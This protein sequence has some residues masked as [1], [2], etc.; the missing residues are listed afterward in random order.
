MEQK[1]SILKRPEVVKMPESMGIPAIDKPSTGTSKEVPEV[2]T[3]NPLITES[4]VEY[5]NYRI[6]QEEYSSRIYM[7]M[8]MWLDEKGFKGA[9]ALWRK[10]SDE[11]LT[12]ADI[13]RKYLLSFGVQP[14]TP[15]LDPPQQDFSGSLPQ[16]VEL[17]YEHEIEVSTQIKKMADHALGMKDH[18]LYELCLG[19]LKEQ[20]EEHDKMQTW[21]DKLKT[22]GK[23]PLALRLLDNDMGEVAC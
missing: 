11:E 12:H 5:L 21:M 20:V 19:Y 9:A 18:I 3:M 13:A 17:S 15:R 1:P 16:I 10:Y 6:Q 23:D 22:F 7:A 4:C 2:K 8:T 14:L